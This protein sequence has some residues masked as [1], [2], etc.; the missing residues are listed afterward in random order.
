MV[1]FVTPPPIFRLERQGWC[2]PSKKKLVR[3]HPTALTGSE[4]PRQPLQR[5]LPTAPDGAGK[6]PLAHARLPHRLTQNG[7]GSVMHESW[8]YIN[9]QILPSD[10]TNVSGWDMITA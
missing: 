8:V 1:F 4:A 9:R 7:S 10:L 3:P 2:R 5:T 6:R